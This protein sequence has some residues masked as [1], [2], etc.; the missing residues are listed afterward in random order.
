[1]R[2]LIDLL[3]RGRHSLVVAGDEVRT[4][5]GCGV[6]D[7]YRLLT[8]EPNLLR[9]ASVADKVVGKGAAALMVEGGV[10]EVYADVVSTPALALFRVGG[11]PVRYG[12]E[13][14]HI[15]NRAGNGICP[16]E[17]LCRDCTTATECIP[18]IAAFMQRLSASSA[19]SDRPSATK[20]NR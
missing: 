14:P 17:Q 15:V 18:L 11:I 1:M 12:Q 7:L 5:D 8:N 20:E 19:S 3:H 13:V 9:R 4:F 16:V 6:S 10:R 2:E